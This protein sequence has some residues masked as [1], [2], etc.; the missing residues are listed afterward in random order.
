[1]LFRSKTDPTNLTSLEHAI[2]NNPMGVIE[3][4]QQIL[5]ASPDNNNDNSR[6]GSSRSFHYGYAVLI[7]IAILLLLLISILVLSCILR[8]K[9]RR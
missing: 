5:H 7:G 1:M 4:F 9:Y 2:L 6:D 3:I 8:H